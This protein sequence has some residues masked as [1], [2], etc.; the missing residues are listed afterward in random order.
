MMMGFDL[1]HGRIGT[2]TVSLVMNVGM[3]CM[4]MTRDRNFEIACRVEQRGCCVND[5]IAVAKLQSRVQRM[6]V[7]GVA[8]MEAPAMVAA[9]LRRLEHKCIVVAELIP[10]RPV[11]VMPAIM[12]LFW[13]RHRWIMI[14]IIV[15]VMAMVVVVIVV[16]VALRRCGRRCVIV[17]MGVRP[18]SN[19]RTNSWLD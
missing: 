5:S 16:V 10:V 3:V 11:R 13:L 18:I 17:S 6:Q 9:G 1:A 7:D 8:G 4:V 15:T 2:V 19:K 12:R 14:A